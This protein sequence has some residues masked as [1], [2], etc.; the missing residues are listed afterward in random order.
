MTQ[1]HEGGKTR[2]LPL[3]RRVVLVPSVLHFHSIHGDLPGTPTLTIS[4]MWKSLIY[5]LGDGRVDGFSIVSALPTQLHKRGVIALADCPR[6]RSIASADLT[7]RRPGITWS[8]TRNNRG[9]RGRRRVI[10]PEARRKALLDPYL[11]Y[12]S[13]VP[14]LSIVT[15]CVIIQ[16]HKKLMGM[17]CNPGGLPPTGALRSSLSSEL[18]TAW[19]FCQLARLLMAFKKSYNSWS[20]SH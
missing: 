10:R 4:L 2:N 7:S 13:N 20:L 9:S 8:E 11:N 15:H 17:G 5:R 3:R 16:R 12:I 1:R 19:L 14:S 18:Y 6:R